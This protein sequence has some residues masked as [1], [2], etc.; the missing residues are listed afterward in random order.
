MFVLQ[1]VSPPCRCAARATQQ[2]G[3]G[4]HGDDW[5]R[6]GRGGGG[7]RVSVRVS[8]CMRC[9]LQALT[10]K[11]PCSGCQS[12]KCVLQ[13]RKGLDRE[14]METLGRGRAGERRGGRFL[15]S[16]T[17][18]AFYN[19]DHASPWGWIN[20]GSNMSDGRFATGQ[21]WACL[22]AII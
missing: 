12:C 3:K 21:R 1:A 6:R 11:R 9:A 18:Y 15:M 19:V 5:A 10:A 2:A 20:H 22:N 8:S 4:V 7:G 16:C 13:E 14:F 17:R